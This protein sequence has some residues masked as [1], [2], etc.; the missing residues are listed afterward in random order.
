MG[1]R[2]AGFCE[3][4]GL[5]GN[6]WLASLVLLAWS[7]WS[8]GFSGLY[9]L[10]STT[11]LWLF[12]LLVEIRLLLLLYIYIYYCISDLYYSFYYLDFNYFDSDKGIGVQLKGVIPEFRICRVCLFKSCH[13]ICA[14][15]PSAESSISLNSMV[16]C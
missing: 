6:E 10:I 9:R 13:Y 15:E 8:G 2:K 12:P 5:L 11:T 3:W 7:G 14:C 16:G 1:G 4:M